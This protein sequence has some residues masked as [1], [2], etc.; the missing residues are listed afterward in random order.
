L[1]F[2]AEGLEVEVSSSLTL[3]ETAEKILLEVKEASITFHRS[4][5]AHCS[6]GCSARARR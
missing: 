3:R 1:T 6:T 2:V 4:F 5:C